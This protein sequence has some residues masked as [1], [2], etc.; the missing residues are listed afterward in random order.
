M[1][2]GDA[3]VGK[4][5]AVYAFLV[6][7]LKR[8]EP[9]VLITAA[10]APDEVAQQIGVLSP[11][12]HEYEQLG[13]VR[14][15]D[16]SIPESAPERRDATGTRLVTN[17]PTDH[18]GMLSSLVQAT[19]ALEDG[20]EKPLRV[21]FLGLSATLAHADERL[22]LQ[23]VQNLVGVLKPHEALALYALESGSLPQT[24][25]ETILSR[26]DGAIYFK[27]EG[28]KSYLSVQGV[29]EVETRDWVEYR[30][31]NRGLVMG[32]FSLERIR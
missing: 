21:G 2:I 12:F 31:T 10:R 22:R 18:A 19:K 27:T 1:L 4:E 29:G 11:Q 26:M 25:M 5:V 13:L 32:S 20:T 8:G 7:G 16:A 24:Q 17:G 15:I 23:F 3:F 28:G 6:E 30:A 14:W 9:A